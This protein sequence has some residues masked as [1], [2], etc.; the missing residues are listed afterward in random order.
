MSE[1]WKTYPSN[2]EYEVSNFGRVRSWC[3]KGPRTPQNS[4]AKEPRL[5]SPLLDKTGH[6]FL[7]IPKDGKGKSITLFVHTMVLETFLGPCP[8]ERYTIGN[9]YGLECRHLDGNPINNTP[10]NLVWGTRSQ[11]RRDQVRHGTAVRGEKCRKKLTEEQVW[12][13]FQS[14]GSQTAVALRYGITQGEVSRIKSGKKWG[15]L[16]SQGR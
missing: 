5:M 16:T 12:E 11:N 6:L 7:R 15:W 3:P 14:K 1:I 10:D 13:I 9:H 2:P 4:R 8:G